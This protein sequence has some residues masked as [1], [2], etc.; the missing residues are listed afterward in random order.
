MTNAGRSRF[1]ASQGGLPVVLYPTDQ[2]PTIASIP[3]GA[4]VYDTTDGVLKRK[5][6]TYLVD[7]SYNVIGYGPL[8]SAPV[9]SEALLGAYYLQTD[10][11]DWP[12]GRLWKYRGNAYLN[13]SSSTDLVIFNTPLASDGLKE[14]W[15]LEYLFKVDFSPT[16]TN[17]MFQ[18]GATKDANFT[19]DMI[20]TAISSPRCRW[21]NSDNSSALG[22]VASMNRTNSIWHKLK[23]WHDGTT[24]Y[25][26]F[27][28]G[29]VN[30]GSLAYWS[31][32]NA[33]DIRFSNSANRPW[34]LCDFKASRNG[35][36]L[37]YAPFDDLSGSVIRDRSGNGIN[38]ELTDVSPLDF[39]QIN[40]IPDQ[41]DI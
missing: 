26:Q 16:T 40:L 20:A 36:A 30:S 10:D 24:G 23:V 4:V 5:I 17:N 13:S 12:S 39:W 15:E 14:P 28:G 25:R 8:S 22:I 29:S 11:P 31:P 7:I 1:I 32:L 21:G 41:W 3:T 6:G 37:V 9:A 27:S 34:S 33:G 38:G 2:F 35:V 19:N 18:L